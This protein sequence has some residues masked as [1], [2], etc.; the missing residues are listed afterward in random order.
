VFSGLGGRHADRVVVLSAIG[1]AQ[2]GSDGG[3]G[4]ST[5]DDVRVTETKAWLPPD[6]TG[7]NGMSQT[8]EDLAIH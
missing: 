3:S 1:Y 8:F 2:L 6:G 4:G 5:D 7:R